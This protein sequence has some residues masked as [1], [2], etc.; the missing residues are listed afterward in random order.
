MPSAAPPAPQ[1][2]PAPVDV[3]P[4]KIVK[5]VMPVP[6]A[7]LP[8]NAKGFV[9]VSFSIGTNGRVSGIEI[10]ESEP[11]GMFD[12]AAQDAV[13]KW[14]YEPRKENGTAVETTARAKLVFDPSN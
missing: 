3:V 14:V 9:V 10:V 1:A 4:A 12:K 7:N 6:P 5:R 2:V 11:Q 13:R 8:R